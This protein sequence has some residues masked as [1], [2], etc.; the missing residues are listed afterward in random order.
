MLYQWLRLSRNWSWQYYGICFKLKPQQC[1]ISSLTRGR[2][3]RGDL[4][5]QLGLLRINR[6]FKHLEEGRPVR[7]FA[8]RARCSEEM[9]DDV[10]REEV[11]RVDRCAFGL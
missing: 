9:N 1:L 11:P 4:D 2:L 3:A 5:Q 10:L 6:P 8:A 7:T